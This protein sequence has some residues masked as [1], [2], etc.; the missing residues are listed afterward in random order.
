MRRAFSFSWIVIC[1][2]LASCTILQSSSPHQFGVIYTNASSPDSSFVL[3][4]S[5]GKI[6]VQEDIPAMGIFQ[7]LQN[8]TGDILLPVQYENKLYSFS[9]ADK[10]SKET[11]TRP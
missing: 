1:F 7:I 10:Q 6:T 4:D 3:F 2:F 11:Q 8:N 9:I 5:N